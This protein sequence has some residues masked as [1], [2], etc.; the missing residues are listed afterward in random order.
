MNTSQKHPHYTDYQK[1]K[2]N[3]PMRPIISGIGSTLHKLACTLSRILTSL[4]S[5]M[6]PSHI[7]NSGELLNKLKNI[8]IKNKYMASLDIKSLYTNISIDPT[9]EKK[10]PNKSKN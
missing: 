7:K 8:D 1:H 2:P 9:K 4:L 6:S 3:I 5:T 10:N